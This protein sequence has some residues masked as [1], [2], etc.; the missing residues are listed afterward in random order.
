MA[1]GCGASESPSTPKKGIANRELS[2][3]LSQTFGAVNRPAHR[4]RVFFHKVGPLLQAIWGKGFAEL[5]R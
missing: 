4:I 3:N 5:D 2:D 1:N